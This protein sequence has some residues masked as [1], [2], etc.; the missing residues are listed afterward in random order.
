MILL[1]DYQHDL[2]ARTYAAWITH[3][4]VM[5]QSATGSGKTVFFC[6]MLREH[7]EDA[8][9]IAHRQELVG[10]ISLSLGRSGVFHQLICASSTARMI[11]ALHHSTLGKSY[12]NPHAPIRVAGVD[13]LLKLEPAPW[14]RRVKLIVQDEA[15]HV[16]RANKWG[17]AAAMFPEAKGLFVTATPIRADGM[18]LGRAADGL[19]DCLIEAPGM[20][21]LIRM[22]YLT[23]Y[24][25]R[26]IPSDVDYS[27]VPLAA[28][29]DLSLPALR[30]A[31][32]KS[33]T[34]VGN[35]V[36]T[37]LAHTPGALSIGFAVDVEHAKE[38]SDAF[39]QQGVPSEVI[40]AKTHD[41]AR[42]S[43]LRRFGRGELR[44]VMNV[45]LF[46]EGFDLPAI[47][48]V[49]MVRKTE[50]FSL[51]S[52]QFG[53]MLR[54]MDGKEFGILH[55]HVGNV[56]R[57]GLP[58]APRDWTAGLSRRERRGKSKPSDA[59]PMRQCY[60]PVCMAPYERIY[61]ACPYCGTEPI[62]AERTAPEHV[63]G[64]IALYDESTL[65]ALRGEI[66]ANQML[67][68]S[69][70]Q[71][72]E[73]IGRLKRVHAEKM[74][75]LSKLQEAIALWAGYHTARGDSISEAQRR[76]YFTFGTDVG[77]AQTLKRAAAEELRLAVEEKIKLDNIVKHDMI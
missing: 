46:G 59:I 57:H 56:I 69:L 61:R 25:I 72:A 16:L 66:E 44:V 20:R 67:N 4:N 75:E 64:D 21:D 74:E 18:G 33:G 26:G 17:R 7:T 30:A 62:I 58:D 9:S 34:I 12:I 35:V 28:S 19:V 22:G 8:V 65:A 23:G 24:K 11:Q 32:H 27:G 37:Y 50:S 36:N 2:K 68:Y 41:A 55:D 3:Q 29:G 47:E 49:I 5:V 43:I 42:S 63:D 48:S 54:I 40:T 73:V 51:Y 45:D 10:Q 13:T 15:H 52:Q 6:D 39:R 76:F 14:M 60:N 70:H 31:V 53:R 1:R 38:M 71:P 77:T